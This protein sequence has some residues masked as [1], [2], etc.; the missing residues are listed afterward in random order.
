MK[1]WIIIRGKIYLETCSPHIPWHSVYPSILP[2]PLTRTQLDLDSSE[3][4]RKYLAHHTSCGIDNRLKV[5][6]SFWPWLKIWTF[7]IHSKVHKPTF[8]PVVPAAPYCVTLAINKSRCRDI[9]V[10]VTIGLRVRVHLMRKLSTPKH[11][12]WSWTLNLWHLLHKHRAPLGERRMDSSLWYACWGAQW[13]K[14]VEGD[15]HLGTKVYI[16][17]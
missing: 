10:S 17:Q 3:P 9:H 1:C 7:W 11:L 4:R 6:F 12:S 2:P 15:M 8:V 16:G 14:V 13:G 5:P